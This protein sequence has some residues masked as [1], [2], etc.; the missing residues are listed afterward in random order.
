MIWIHVA[1]YTTL[2]PHPARIEHACVMHLSSN[3]KYSLWIS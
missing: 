3:T 1:N 2:F